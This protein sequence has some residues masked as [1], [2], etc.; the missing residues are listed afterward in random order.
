LRCT[1][2]PG[3][4]VIKEGFY[5]LTGACQGTADKSVE[6]NLGTLRVRAGGG[7]LTLG[8]A[9]PEKSTGW[10]VYSLVLVPPAT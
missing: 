5:S 9:H 7:T 8:A 3:E 10:R 4:V 1:G 2:S 6:Q